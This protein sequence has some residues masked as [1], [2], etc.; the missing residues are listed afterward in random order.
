[1]SGIG[2]KGARWEGGRLRRMKGQE[3][4]A[5]RLG[6]SAEERTRHL[7]K[8]RPKQTVKNHVCSFNMEIL[9]SG[10]GVFS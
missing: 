9:F 10:A 5:G 1:M 2:G 7:R 3:I 8:K 4:Q 6:Q